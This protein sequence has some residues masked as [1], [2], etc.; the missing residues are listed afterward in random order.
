[1]AGSQA[2]RRL[3]CGISRRTV[4]VEPESLPLSA[5]LIENLENWS[6][7]FIRTVGGW[8]R[9]G[10]FASEA[11]A[12][13]FVRQGKLLSTELQDELGPG[14]YVLYMPE[15]IRPPGVRL[16]GFGAR[17]RRTIGKITSKT[18]LSLDRVSR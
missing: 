8:P 1:M 9:N 10:G 17:L 15:P 11:Q 6:A 4:D 7:L 18:D 16:A 12:E 13:S 2:Q 3:S 5:G 14:Y